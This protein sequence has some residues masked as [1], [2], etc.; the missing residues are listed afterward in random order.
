MHVDVI[1]VIVYLLC[2]LVGGFIVTVLLHELRNPDNVLYEVVADGEG[3]VLG[4]LIELLIFGYFDFLL[5]LII[6]V[7]SSRQ[8]SMRTRADQTLK[9]FWKL[10]ITRCNL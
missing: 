5:L 1:E 6:R 3:H 8:S 4:C 10:E 7:V 2:V 9:W